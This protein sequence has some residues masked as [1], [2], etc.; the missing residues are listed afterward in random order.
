MPTED[1]STNSQEGRILAALRA[2]KG[3]EIAMP[4][5]A[6]IGSGKPDGFCMVH[7]RIDGLRHKGVNIPPPR[8][9]RVDGQRRTFYRLIEDLAAGQSTPEQQAAN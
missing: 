8:E 9:E 6:R 7:S 4:E 1:I 5:L 3:G 2:A